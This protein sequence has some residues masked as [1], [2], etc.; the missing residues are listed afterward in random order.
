MY[1]H[2]MKQH[3]ALKGK[4]KSFVVN[5]ELLEIIVLNEINQTDKFKYHMYSHTRSSKYK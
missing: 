3:S 5:W 4:F 2:T 1:L